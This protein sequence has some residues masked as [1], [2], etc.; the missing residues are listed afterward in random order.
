MVIMSKIRRSADAL[1]SLKEDLEFMKLIK[2]CKL[3]KNNSGK[4]FEHK[5]KLNLP[6][7]SDYRFLPPSLELMIADAERMCTE[8][9][10]S[11]SNTNKYIK[12]AERMLAKQVGS[13]T[14]PKPIR[15]QITPVKPNKYLPKAS[16]QELRLQ[17]E[18]EIMAQE[19]P[20]FQLY[21]DCDEVFFEG[22]HTTS[23]GGNLYQLKLVLPHYYPD[24]MPGLFLT[25]PQILMKYGY[26]GFINDEGISHSFHT[27]SNGP[28]G[29]IQICHSNEESWDA[30]RTAVGAFT[31]GIL[32]VEAYDVHL[33]NGRDIVDTLYEFERIQ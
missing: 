16:P 33:L 14:K 17:R 32:W 30:S 10:S 11:Q 7:M 12:E 31:K 5:N 15:S 4:G 3:E 22:P 24:E 6:N 20:Q 2:D 19:L 9:E 27:L 21:R 18:K 13:Q 26:A 25:F 29:S 8:W 1:K 28:D 23:T